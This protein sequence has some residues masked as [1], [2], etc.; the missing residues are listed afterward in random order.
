MNA[1]EAVDAMGKIF[2]DKWIALSYPESRVKWTN[3]PG[4]KPTGELP[5]ARV[6]VQHVTGNQ[7]SLRGGIGT[8]RFRATGFITCQI[9]TPIGDGSVASYDVGQSIQDAFR[10][11]QHSNL[12]FKNIRFREVDSGDAV[13][14]QTNVIADFSYDDVM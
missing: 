14:V 4:E 12:W 10:V 13:F 6:I 11:A 9:F 8:R 3:V 5:W 7:A 1:T 2:R